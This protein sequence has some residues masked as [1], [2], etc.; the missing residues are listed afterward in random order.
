VIGHIPLTRLFPGP[1]P[2]LWGLYEPQ[3]LPDFD[4]T[5]FEF[6]KALLA[7]QEILNIEGKLVAPWDVQSVLRPGTLVAIEATLI[8]YSFCGDAPATVCLSPS[9]V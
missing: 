2:Q 1:E 3:I 8:V 5:R 7:Q 6:R 4:P 9:I